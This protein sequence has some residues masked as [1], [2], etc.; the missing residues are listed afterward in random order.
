MYLLM[1]LIRSNAR[2][3]RRHDCRGAVSGEALESRVLLAATLLKDVNT[4]GIASFP[5]EFTEY[6]GAIYFAADGPQ[7]REV[8]RADSPDSGAV[9]LKDIAPGIVGSDPKAF[10]VIGDTLYFSADGHDGAGAELWKTDGTEAG[11][12]RVADINPGSADS[13]PH[14]MADFGGT[15][16]FAAA[17]PGTGEALFK[18]D[19]TAAGTVMVFDTNDTSET[20]GP[21]EIVPLG[22]KL[23]FTSDGDNDDAARL[24]VTD[25]TTAGTRQLASFSK[26]GVSRLT[27]FGDR[28][29][30]TGSD[31]YTYEFAL[32]TSD[33]TTEGTRPIYQMGLAHDITVI[34]DVAY[35]AATGTL[36]KT[37][38]TTAGTVQL[39]SFNPQ[40]PS[41]GDNND[42]V[43][44]DG[45]VYLST[46]GQTGPALWRSDGTPEGTV[47]VRSL[48][49]VRDLTASNGKLFF[50][51][52]DGLWTSDG[53]DAG[54]ALLKS[55][56]A[57][58]VGLHRFGDDM[59]F[60]G[61]SALEGEEPWYSDGTAAGTHLLADVNPADRD[62]VF[63]GPPTPPA[64]TTAPASLPNGR[65]IF[66][67]DAGTITSRDVDLWSTDGTPQGTVMLADF[68]RV[69]AITA[70]NGF[71]YVLAGEAPST[72][73]PLRYS[74]W[75]T[76]GTVQGTSRIVDLRYELSGM[77]VVNGALYFSAIDG[78][79]GAE[80]WRSDGT[81]AGTTRVSDVSP[82]LPS[83]SPRYLTPVG[84]ALFFLSYDE[85]FKLDA[86]G[87]VS[88]VRALPVT[89]N[90]R[91]FTALDTHTM[92][93]RP[94]RSGYPDE[95]WKTDG[96]E[97]GTVV[98]K[99]FDRPSE[100]VGLDL[101]MAV[102]NGLMYF[103]A[104]SPGSPDDVELWRTDGTTAGTVRVKD[105]NPGEKM[106]SS[107]NGFTAWGD[108]VYFSATDPTGG[109]ELWVTDGTEAGTHRVKD[110]NPGPG[111]GL[112][113]GPDGRLLT[114]KN[115]HALWGAIGDRFYFT[116]DDGVHGTELWST[117]GTEAGTTMAYDTA[118]GE[119]ASLARF[120]VAAPGR[121][122]YFA[123]DGLHG[124]EPWAVDLGTAAASVM[125]RYAFYNHSSYDGNDAA[126]D[127]A[128][129]NAIATDKNALLASQDRLPGFDNV[130]G[131]DK[132]INGVMI[133]I[134][135][136]PEGGALS[137]DDFDYGTARPPREV[138][139][140]RG[141]GVD[142]SDRVTLIWSDFNTAAFTANMATA[143][144]WLSLAV[145]A[146]A[147]TGL[148]A[149]DLFSFGNLIGD[150][151]DS[152]TTYRVNALDLAAVKRALN[153][154][155]TVA[156]P[157][158]F[159]RDG[160]TN[161]LDLAIV[162]RSLNHNLSAAPAA[163]PAVAQAMTIAT[164]ETDDHRVPRVADEVLAPA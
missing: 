79:T 153:T 42:V 11:T 45:K 135:G 131:F 122:V 94:A 70:M 75:R 57:T 68:K 118:P 9:L 81:A 18:T 97:E 13:F 151:G 162:K 147:R 43:V 25:G 37:D 117:D 53:T 3:R 99:T 1:N 156:A 143:N 26:F 113:P 100:S 105:I 120:P 63:F 40:A 78:L 19:G 95:L 5:Q 34:G 130:T 124:I 2:N 29:L 152:P 149:P 146:N 90:Q 119:R 109:R 52:P 66:A 160:R 123:D 17:A 125:G 36:F 136:L 91:E 132:G 107:P 85:M 24:F 44:L 138:A 69:D 142:G 28:L 145:K 104:N 8:Y 62:S 16:Y 59:V 148:A 30:F 27:P 56:A 33:G 47:P 112:K 10:A 157:T 58:P 154:P 159:N 86:S 67:A 89:G 116:A 121:V 158:D 64:F 127:A 141:A 98:V 114:A 101:Q 103:A 128:D 72:P 32:W 71:A 133:D 137:A 61:I 84:S 102:A 73:G 110:V 126:A 20:L 39:G 115:L 51:A 12:V 144:G 60:V 108:R 96:T 76:D 15:A 38:G 140:R 14:A 54:T 92:L 87:V 6:R 77:V 111:D 134:A 164:A 35:F 155:T 65:V 7:G 49:G 150:T 31:P 82:G 161:A 74:L 46:D 106:G 21:E 80:L 50:G 93:F 83:S 22:N 55:M 23:F 41:N 129:D 139:V 163:H 48:S 4:V 88:R